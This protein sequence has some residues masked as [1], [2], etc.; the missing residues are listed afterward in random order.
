MPLDTLIARW[1]AIGWLVFGLSHV[2]YPAKWTALILPLRAGENGGFLLGT[3]NLLLGLIV[4][5]GHNV[6]VWR[7]PVIVTLAGW[8][9]TLKGAMY[10]LVP[11]SHVLVM[12][13][14]ERMERGIRAAGVVAMVLGALLTYDSFCRR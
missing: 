12:P 3:F 2:L 4:I 9:M 7:L 14:G 5:L 8:V 13:A 1:F 11:G 10:L 6:W